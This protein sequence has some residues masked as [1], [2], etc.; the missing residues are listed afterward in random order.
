MIGTALIVVGFTAGVGGALRI[1]WNQ[2]CEI[3]EQ[4]TRRKCRIEARRYA[5][6]Q[7]MWFEFGPEKETVAYRRT[8]F[9]AKLDG[10]EEVVELI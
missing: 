5:H 8:E 4:R 3:T 1:T 6:V 9:E 10:I 7:R 2:A